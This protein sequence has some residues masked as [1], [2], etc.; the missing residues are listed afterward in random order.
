[1]NN[2][3]YNEGKEYLKKDDDFDYQGRSRKQYEDSGK[4]YL[5]SAIGLFIMMFILT[6]INN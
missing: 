3:W 6:L 2:H 5:F 4:I 1:M